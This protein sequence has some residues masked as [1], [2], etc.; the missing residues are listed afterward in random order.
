MN[1]TRQ[2]ACPPRPPSSRTS[3]SVSRP[4]DEPIRLVQST[5]Q[6]IEPKPASRNRRAS[7]TEL[8]ST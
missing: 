1:P 3:R 6:T 8:I 7:S 2:T 5:P 4:V